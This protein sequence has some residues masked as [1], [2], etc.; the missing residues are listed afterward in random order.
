MHAQRKALLLQNP[1]VH[2]RSSG[3]AIYG[4]G[5]QPLAYWEACSLEKMRF[6]SHGKAIGGGGGVQTLYLSIKKK[7]YYLSESNP[8]CGY[9]KP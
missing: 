8:V 1:Y 9:F 4:V 2:Y 7:L 5:V 6:T 3:C